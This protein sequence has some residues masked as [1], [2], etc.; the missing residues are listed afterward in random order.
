MGA[1]TKIGVELWWLAKKVL[2]LAQSGDVVCRYMSGVPT[3]SLKDLHELI[4]T[5][6]G[7]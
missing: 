5:H 2:E 3:N 6:A 7:K 4:Q 1:F